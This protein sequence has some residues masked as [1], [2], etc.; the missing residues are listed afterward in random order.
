MVHSTGFPPIV[1]SA[2]TVL[3]L[4]SLPSVRSIEAFEYYAH[5][6]NAFWRI[7]AALFGAAPDMP[8][9]KR[10][11]MLQR[12]GI[13]IWDVLASSIRPGSMDSDIDLSTAKPN[14]FASFLNTY[15]GIRLVCF[16]GKKAAAMFERLVLSKYPDLGNTLRF[17]TLPS[18]SPAFASMPFDAKLRKWSIVAQCK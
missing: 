9:K 14:D 7:M 5:P 18:T 2:A 3:V 16:N 15:S 17:E 6:Q 8:Y 1:D 11:E 13:A 4:G 10:T 12:N